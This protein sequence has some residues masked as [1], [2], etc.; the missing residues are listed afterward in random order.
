MKLQNP[1][2][3]TVLP[4]SEQLHV[5]IE[6]KC[7]HWRGPVGAV[8]A[9]EGAEVASLQLAPAHTGSGLHFDIALRSVHA[10]LGTAGADG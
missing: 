2:F 4:Y 3:K 1:V 5:D 6:V 9:A 8:V 7:V 10:A